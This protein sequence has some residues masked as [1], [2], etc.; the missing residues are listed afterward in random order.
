MKSKKLILGVGVISSVAAIATTVSCSTTWTKWS[1]DP[2]GPTTTNFIRHKASNKEYKVRAKAQLMTAYD[3]VTKTL[4]LKQL[5]NRF[6]LEMA[7][8]YIFGLDANDNIDT[9][10]KEGT[11][12]VYAKMRTFFSNINKNLT[13]NLKYKT[14]TQSV[15]FNAATEIDAAIAG[16][17]N[18]P[19]SPTPNDYAYP[20]TDADIDTRTNQPKPG[21]VLSFATVGAPFLRNSLVASLMMPVS[22]QKYALE[23]SKLVNLP[24]STFSNF[25]GLLTKMDSL[26]NDV[27]SFVESSGLISE[28]NYEVK[29]NGNIETEYLKQFN[30]GANPSTTTQKAN[31]QKNA[32]KFEFLIQALKPN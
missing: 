7:I 2:S 11:S 12:P 15:T 27:Y 4:D 19:S 1:K 8:A 29:M 17:D 26:V 24:K 14:H 9:Y 21:V 31:A 10:W 3:S 6:E 25:T 18:F 16:I 32:M 20:L 23:L 13:I 5:N 22:G 28:M 30:N